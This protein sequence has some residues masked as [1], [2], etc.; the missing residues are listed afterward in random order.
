MGIDWNPHLDGTNRPR[1]LRGN[2]SASRVGSSGTLVGSS[3]SRNGTIH[4]LLG[5]H[6]QA[7]TYLN[8]QSPA[9]IHSH[10]LTYI[11]WEWPSR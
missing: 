10:R 1:R 4:V 5:I 8:T 6:F 2:L 11:F 9:Y 3:T 7:N